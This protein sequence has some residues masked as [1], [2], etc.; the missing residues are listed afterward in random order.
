MVSGC[1]DAPIN[2]IERGLRRKRSEARV[3][4]R[5]VPG[6]AV[7][8]ILTLFMSIVSPNCLNYQGFILPFKLSSAPAAL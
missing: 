7:L 3:E 6:V 2:A 4:I 1:L 5:L 8:I